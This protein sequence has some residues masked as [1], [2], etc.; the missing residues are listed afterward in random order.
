MPEC[1]VSVV[2]AEDILAGNRGKHAGEFTCGQL[3]AM[4]ELPESCTNPKV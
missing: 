2:N 3:S 4:P 1:T